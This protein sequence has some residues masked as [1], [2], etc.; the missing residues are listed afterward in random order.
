[1]VGRKV[2]FARAK[3]GCSLSSNANSKEIV[4][5]YDDIMA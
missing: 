4:F 5:D 3:S 1:M 2:V